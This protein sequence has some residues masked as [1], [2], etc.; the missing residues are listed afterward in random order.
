LGAD[1]FL[2]RKIFLIEGILITVVGLV[3]GLVLGILICWIQTTFSILEFSEGYVVSTYPVHIRIS[4]ILSISVVVML[5]GFLAA[6]YPVRLFTN[7][8]MIE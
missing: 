7:K 6:W 3:L 1:K 5:I 2:I 4:D 8:Y